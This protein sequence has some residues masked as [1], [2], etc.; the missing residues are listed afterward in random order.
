MPST[1]FMIY[2]PTGRPRKDGD[3]VVLKSLGSIGVSV[4]ARLAEMIVEL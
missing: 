1:I 4:S 3:A 2:Y